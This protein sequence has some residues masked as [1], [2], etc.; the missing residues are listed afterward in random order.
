MEEVDISIEWRILIRTILLVSD[1]LRY[2]IQEKTEEFGR[3]CGLSIDNQAVVPYSQVSFE[4]NCV[5]E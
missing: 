4:A 1:G 2:T 3:G 5:R